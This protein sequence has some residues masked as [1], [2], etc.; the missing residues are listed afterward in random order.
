MKDLLLSLL[1]DARLGVGSD[2][3]PGDYQL[4]HHMAQEHQVSAL[5]YNQ[6]YHFPGLPAQLKAEWSREALSINA[7]QA[8]RSARFLELYRRLREGG[9]NALVVKGIVLRSLYP[10]PDNRQSNDEDV[11][12]P[13]D[14]F[15]LAA[16]ILQDSG[17][18]LRHQGLFEYALLDPSCGLSIELHGALFDPDTPVLARYQALFS[19]SFR[20][21]AL[22]NIDGVPVYSL[23]HDLHFLFLVTHLAKHLLF[24]GVGIRQVL[25]IVMY[26][27]AFLDQIN[28]PDVYDKLDRLGLLTLTAN[29]MAIGRSCFHMDRAVPVPEV[30]TDFEPL[31]RDI[32]S[33]GVFGASS[34]ARLHSAPFTLAAA[35][36]EKKLSPVSRLFPPRRELEKRMEYSY[37]REKP[38]LLPAAWGKRLLSY[39]SRRES[40]RQEQETLA[41]GEQR[42]ALLR[43]YGVIL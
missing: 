15:P 43:K 20:S 22:H 16:Q 34:Q 12:I 8:M 3:Q 19:D 33:A 42:V 23:S 31:L 25:D 39:L 28:W 37:L 6:L 9:V 1:N 5:I 2:P 29:L 35:E 32:L 21:P 36:G 40:S 38:W 4:L 26:A 13:M 17:V 24:S 11:Y 18:T 14:Q 41:L 10:Q 30:P 7:F 27:E